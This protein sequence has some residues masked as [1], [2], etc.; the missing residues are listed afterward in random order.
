MIFKG[1]KIYGVYQQYRH[2]PCICQEI[3]LLTNLQIDSSRESLLGEFTGVI[4]QWQ[5]LPQG[6]PADKLLSAA[7]MRYLGTV[8]SLWQTLFYKSTFRKM[9]NHSGKRAPKYNIFK[10]A[11]QSQISENF[12]FLYSCQVTI[13]TAILERNRM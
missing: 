10:E 9:I 4:W 3:G 2:K 8:F 6:A 12:K 7:G 5:L 1:N 13:S 11:L